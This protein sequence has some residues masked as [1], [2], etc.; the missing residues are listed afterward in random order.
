MSR[1]IISGSLRM[2]CGVVYLLFIGFGLAIGAE[3]YEKITS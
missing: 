1:N 3:A 2:Y